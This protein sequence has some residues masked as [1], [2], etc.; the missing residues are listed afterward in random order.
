VNVDASL[1][2][3]LA[4]L[5]GLGPVLRALGVF[6]QTWPAGIRI[7]DLR[8]PFP[9]SDA[10]ASVVYSSHTL[11]HL[12]RAQGER[13]LAEC[14]RVLAPA[15]VLRIV[16]PDLA[17]LLA[18]YEKGVF[19]A[20]EVVERLGV[21]FE[22]PGDGWWK[23][24]LAPFFRHP[25]RCM[26]DAESLLDAVRAAGLD[27]RVHAPG[28]SRIGDLASVERPER[29]GSSVIVEGVKPARVV[30]GGAGA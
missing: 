15:G 17:A 18:D 1:G 14:A 7:H 9:W 28:L 6:R 22:H 8:R 26:Y 29:T 11:E 4:N 16:V 19:P 24:R 3:R 30:P 27:A 2:A 21:G 5:P 13:F 12:T 25:H 23:A 20:T 10:S